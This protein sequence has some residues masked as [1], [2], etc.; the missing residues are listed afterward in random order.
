MVS[1]SPTKKKYKKLFLH[2]DYGLMKTP[3]EG[4]EEMAAGELLCG[5]EESLPTQ[6]IWFYVGKAYMFQKQTRHWELKCIF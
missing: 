3:A 5:L 4:W 6:R 2:A 1:P